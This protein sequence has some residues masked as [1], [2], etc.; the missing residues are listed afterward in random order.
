[1]FL[2]MLVEFSLENSEAFLKETQTLCSFQDTYT[3]I[4]RRK[5]SLDKLITKVEIVF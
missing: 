4:F 5:W 3:A 2:R 1:M